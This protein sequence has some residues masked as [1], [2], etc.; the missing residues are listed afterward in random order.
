MAMRSSWEVA[1]PNAAGIDVGG[2]MHFVAIPPDRGSEIVRKFGV[3]T[4]ELHRMAQ[5]LIDSGVDTVAMEST[6]VYW[7]PVFEVLERR[8]LRVVLVNARHVHNVP[9]RKSDVVDCQ[10]LQQ[11]MSFGLLQGAFRP[12]DQVCALRALSRHRDTLITEQAR[13]VQRMQKALVQMER[14]T[15]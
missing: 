11:L 14:A 8:G 2:A 15:R 7:I 9:G 1:F 6:G 4:A 10:W 12:E 13:Q 3:C 5:W